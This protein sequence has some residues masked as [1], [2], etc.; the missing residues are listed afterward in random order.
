SR[1]I[2]LKA[3]LEVFG[4]A[5][6]DFGAGTQVSFEGLQVLGAAF[7]EPAAHALPDLEPENG[8]DGCGHLGPGG[9]RVALGLGE[10]AP[11]ELETAARIQQTDGHLNHAAVAPTGA[12][13]DVAG[14]EPLTGADK[15]HGNRTGLRGGGPRD[16]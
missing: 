1:A 15:G 16:D 11:P 14:L 13:N 2:E 4:A 7:R 9:K 10:I 6:G 12:G 5:Q 8:E 3:A